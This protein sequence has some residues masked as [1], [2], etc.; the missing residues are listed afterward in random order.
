MDFQ[1]Q[2]TQQKT[3][4]NWMFGPCREVGRISEVFLQIHCVSYN[5]PHTMIEHK[6]NYVT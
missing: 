2:V 3:T 6:N 1:L 5:P 4:G